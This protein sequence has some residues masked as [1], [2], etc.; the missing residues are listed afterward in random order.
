MQKSEDSPFFY[1]SVVIEHIVPKG[2]DYLFKRWHRSLIK[3]AKQHEGF[4]RSDTCPPL[5][6]YDNAVKWYSIIHF[7]TPEHLNAWIESEE[8]KRVLK[9]GQDVFRHSRFKSFTTGLEGWFS[10]RS[11]NEQTRLGP[12]A[13]K[14]ILS[15][16]V[17][18]YPIIMV[19]SWLF[20]QLGIMQNWPLASAML[21]NN[22]ITSTIL[23]LVIMPI[24]VRLLSF[25]LRPAYR[26]VPIKI[27]L[28]GVAI[29]AAAMLTMVIIFNH[30]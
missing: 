5:P 14:Q 7:D 23:T 27:E 11:R 19:Q 10:E 28:S 21:I 2:R 29:V 4:L 1:S 17:G 26:L 16:V 20:Q 9:L 25:W 8:R 22:L 18:L 30:L 12:P 13:W 6:C 24:V 15:V 3:T